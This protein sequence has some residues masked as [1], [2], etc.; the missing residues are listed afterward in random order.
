MLLEEK[1]G[2]PDR[3]EKLPNTCSNRGRRLS[4][5]WGAGTPG[6]MLQIVWVQSCCQEGSAGPCAITGAGVRKSGA[7]DRGRKCRS[8]SSRLR[9]LSALADEDGP[10]CSTASKLLPRHISQAL[11]R[12]SSAAPEPRQR[13]AAALTAAA[14]HAGAMPTPHVQL[15]V[16]LPTSGHAV[17]CSEC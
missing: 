5:R 14:V 16:T 11:H 10:H 8:G 2:D 12:L 9:T 6:M 15:E 1:A 7:F 4:K 13:F 3:N 17:I